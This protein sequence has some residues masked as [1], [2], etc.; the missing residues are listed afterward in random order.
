MRSNLASHGHVAT[1]RVSA[2]PAIKLLWGDADSVA[3]HMS[4]LETST[5]QGGQLLGQAKGTAKLQLSIDRLSFGPLA[6][7]S[8]H[9]AKHG[10]QLTGTASLSES[11]LRAA[12]PPGFDVQPIASGGGELLLRASASLFG[13]GLSA[14][15]AVQAQDG[16][17][18][19]QPVGVPFAG[20][21]K[22]TV[23]SDP[24]V[25]VEGIGAQP[26]ADGGYALTATA[27]LR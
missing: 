7:T 14:N 25:F 17:L 12:L 1:I 21:V 15:A 3:V 18:V 10:S 26:G 13:V 20:L 11:A 22:L 16:S 5:D 4:D 6:L 19:V 24:H 27:R 23:F 2:F 8:V 9:A